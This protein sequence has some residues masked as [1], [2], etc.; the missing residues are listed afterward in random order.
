MPTP[1]Q[2]K[3]HQKR[4]QRGRAKSHIDTATVANQNMRPGKSPDHESELLL[5]SHRNRASSGR[6]IARAT[7]HPSDDSVEHIPELGGNN[8]IRSVRTATRGADRPPEV[9][10]R[11]FHARVYLLRRRLKLTRLQLARKA[12]LAERTIGRIE[13]GKQSPTLG[14]AMALAR[15]LGVKL[16]HLVGGI[17]D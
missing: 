5:E 3:A 17:D 14:S 4:L 2:R 11:G 6:A 15:A 9:L 7:D 16:A 10:P 12:G 1:A 8:W 13:L